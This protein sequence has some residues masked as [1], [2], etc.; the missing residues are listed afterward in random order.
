[1]RR[2]LRHHLWLGLPRLCPQ[3]PGLLPGA[4]PAQHQPHRAARYGP[5]PQPCGAPGRTITLLYVPCM[6]V[7]TWCWCPEVPHVPVVL[8][9]SHAPD[10]H[11]PSPHV[12]TVPMP[13]SAP[14][15]TVLVTCGA[16]SP[17]FC[18]APPSCCPSAPGPDVSPSP[19]AY[20]VPTVLMPCSAPCPC[21]PHACVP[22]VLMPRG[23]PCPRCPCV[24]AGCSRQDEEFSLV[25][26]IGSFMNNFMTFPTGFIF[27]RFGTT[28][29]RLVAM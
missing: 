27:D 18:H 21:C 2:L 1:M 25:F 15:P 12:P 14:C 24:S 8:V 28:I 19:A 22:T 20:S 4:V 6:L 10:S 9:A 17:S 29:A 11:C 26:T 7:S 13:C 23:A 3:G 16:P 5:C